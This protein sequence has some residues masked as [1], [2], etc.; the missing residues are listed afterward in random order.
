MK[1]Q[2][3]TLV[4]LDDKCRKMAQIIKEKKIKRQQTNNKQNAQDIMNKAY[5]KE[6]LANLESQLKLAE[7]DKIIE[8]KRLK[9]QL[10]LQ[11]Q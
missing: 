11:D 10:K 8:E 7:T 6:D 2:H 3:E 9:E 1:T 4:A 5:T